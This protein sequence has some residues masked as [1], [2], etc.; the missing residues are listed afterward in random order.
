[1]KK[2]FCADEILDALEDAWGNE[3]RPPSD[4]RHEEPLDGLILT[5]LSQNTNDKNR[6]KAFNALKTK[7]PAWDDVAAASFEDVAETIHVAGLGCTK[8]DRILKV[9]RIIKGKFGEHSIKSLAELNGAEAKEF[10]VSLPGV[11]LK[12]AACVLAFDLGMPAFPVDTHVARVSRRLGWVPEKMTPDK[13]QEY[14]EGVLPARR[15]RGAHLNIIQHGRQICRA[16]NPLCADCVIAK[17]CNF[18]K[19]LDV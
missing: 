1:M 6:D 14:L 2:V 9:L 5:M 12:T 10:L 15:F 7:Y 13:I 4:L 11:G 8:A 3:K 16:R 18:T 19:H 17:W